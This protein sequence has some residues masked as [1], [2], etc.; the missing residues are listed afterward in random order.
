ML[1]FA[2][3]LSLSANVGAEVLLAMEMRRPYRSLDHHQRI[4]RVAR[5]VACSMGFLLLG[6]FNASVIVLIAFALFSVTAATDLETCRIPPDG[7]TYGSVLILIALAFVAG[8]LPKLRDVVVAQAMCFLVMV[9]A[10]TFARA[11]SPGDI[12]V[13][14]QYGATCGSLPVVMAGLLAETVLR[15]GLLVCIVGHALWVKNNRRGAIT[16]GLHMRLPH[17][18]VAWMGVLAALIAQGLGWI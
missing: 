8:G 14:M 10:V 9:L 6:C 3:G 13:L 16:R 4:L 7:F 11:A 18:P 17:A 2:L 12:K 15:L 5:W 1:V